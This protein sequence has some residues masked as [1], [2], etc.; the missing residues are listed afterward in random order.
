MTATSSTTTKRSFGL[1]AMESLGFLESPYDSTNVTYQEPFEAIPTSS[2]FSPPQTTVETLVGKHTRKGIEGLWDTTVIDA[3]SLVD[4]RPQDLGRI[5][6]RRR[7][8]WTPIV[9]TALLVFGLLYLGYWMYRQPSAQ[10]AA[11]RE[12]VSSHAAQLSSS[13][14]PAIALAGGLIGGQL[15]ADYVNT[16]SQVDDSAR[17]LFTSSGALSGSDDTIR[18][19]A[20]A[21]SS[22]ALADSQ[23]IREAAAYRLTLE[24]IL[25]M[26]ELVTDP[27]LTD[28]AAATLAFGDWRAHLAEVTEPLPRT[29]DEQ[30]SAQL[31]EFLASLRRAQRQY[32][33]ALE[34]D[35]GISATRVLD[36]LESDLDNLRQRL[37]SAFDSIVMDL[38][39]SMKDTQAD[40][41]RLIG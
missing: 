8:R 32:V 40:L 29:V 23:R 2:S 17:E 33:N 20:S 4:W 11:A 28:I 6:Q 36:G 25:R 10:A 12:A 38:K 27:S 9:I 18:Q 15:D 7:I 30:L 22:Q 13:L 19:L 3:P 1:P 26:P 39:T 35:D 37:Y 41:A 34:D 5:L 16:L 31:D 14:E 21:T 24:P